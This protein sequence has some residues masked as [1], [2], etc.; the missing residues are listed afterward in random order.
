V[1]DRRGEAS[2]LNNL[3]N[4]YFNLG[5]IST[6]NDYYQQALTIS[7]ETGDKYNQGI[8]LSNLGNIA[9]ANGHYDQAITHLRDAV[10]I[11]SEIGNKT[12]L[13]Y[14]H[15]LL[16]RVYWFAGELSNALST[17]QQARE[18]NTPKYNHITTVWYGCIAICIKEMGDIQ[19]TF[20]EGVTHAD[21]W[22][23]QTPHDYDALYCRGLVYAGLWLVTGD[24]AHYANAIK[25]YTKA[26]MANQAIGVLREN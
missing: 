13:Q 26:K 22:L 4:A 20:H 19:A 14:R 12:L 1:Q 15:S 18:Y 24:S 17:I 25:A 5:Q 3:G 23:I 9:T 7:K 16:A 21:T 10:T 2:R 6:A 11:T 8:S